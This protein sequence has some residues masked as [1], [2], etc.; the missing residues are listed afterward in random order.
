MYLNRTLSTVLLV[1]L[2]AVFSFS[3]HAAPRRGVVVQVTDVQNLNMAL[4]NS[5]NTAKVMPGVPIEVVVYG[6]AIVSLAM[7][8]PTGGKIDE[9]R[10]HGIKVI[11]CEESM[12][13]KNLSKKDM[14]FGIEYVP[15]GLAEIVSKQFKGW[16]YARP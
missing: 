4:T 11:A 10:E 2:A 16:A 5:I 9:A 7:E 6:P 8:S 12:T 14:Y 13:G 1:L 15:Y 3:A